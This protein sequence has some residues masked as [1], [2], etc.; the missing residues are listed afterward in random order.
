MC[1]RGK[2]ESRRLEGRVR[3]HADFA[4]VARSHTF[5]RPSSKPVISVRAQ[6]HNCT[7]SPSPPELTLRSSSSTTRRSGPQSRA[8]P[9]WAGPTACCIRCL[10]LHPQ[11]PRRQSRQP[12]GNGGV[13][14]GLKWALTSQGQVMRDPFACAATGCHA[15]RP[16]ANAH[17]MCSSTPPA[18]IFQQAGL[19]RMVSY[20]RRRSSSR[21]TLYASCTSWNRFSSARPTSGL[22]RQEEGRL[23]GQME[24]WSRVG[25]MGCM[26]NCHAARRALNAQPAAF[27]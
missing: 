7:P 10:P 25:C 27:A 12:A 9:R 11:T 6:Q 18:L 24:S 17:Y 1:K 13:G 8:R 4:V 21:S 3:R 15:A 26:A 23:V 19:T 20:W 14:D 16:G 5:S 22:L 2:E